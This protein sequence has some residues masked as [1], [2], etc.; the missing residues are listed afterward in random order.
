[1]KSLSI[2]NSVTS[3]GS[4]AFYF[5]V[6]LVS[7]SLPNSISVLER[8]VFDR[9]K[10]L[11]TI[12]IPN[13]VTKIGEGAF[14]LCE[15]LTS[16]VIPSSVKTIED[17]PFQRCFGLTQIVVEEGNT[18]YYSDNDC[19]AIIEKSSNTL[20]SGCKNTTITNSVKSIGQD[21]FEFCTGLTSIIIPSSVT[22]INSSAFSYCSN[23]TS[24]TSYVTDVFKTG[25]SVFYGCSNATLYVPKGLVSKYQS[26]ADWNS[27]THIEEIPGIDI[28]MACNDL[29]KVLINGYM[30]FTNKVGEASLYDGGENTFVFTPNEGCMLKQVLINGLDVTRSVKDNKLTTTILDGSSMNVIFSEEGG[31]VNG[32]G[33]VNITDV[34]A[35]VNIILGK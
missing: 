1:M 5:C 12:T 13:S 29:G 21:A 26:T 10:S 34:V 33:V 4:S 9:C 7:I 20:I 25:G 24:I 16:V 22:S 2:P 11:Q 19:N 3:I 6:G 32:D 15:N 30:D 18:S 28:P 27:I 35:L 8:G 17:N 23:L 14:F 31:D